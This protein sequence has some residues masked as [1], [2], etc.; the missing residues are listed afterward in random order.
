MT[1]KNKLHEK[2][3]G[4][5]MTAQRTTARTARRTARRVSCAAAVTAAAGLAAL[6]LGGA[7]ASTAA[8]AAVQTNCAARPSA[9][10]YP[11]ATN[12]GVPAGT[13]LKTVPGQ[14]TS[15]TG[16]SYSTATGTLTVS[17][18]GATLTG[19]KIT[20]NVNITASNV[21]L[22]NDTVVS[23]GGT[24][25][26]S[27]RHTANVTIQNSNVGGANATTGRVNYAVDDIY[28]DS[29]GLVV[30]NDNITNWRVGVNA[31]AGL[32][33]ANYIHSPGF[34]AG[35]HTDGIYDSEG[36]SQL[37]ISNNT[38]LNS[39]NQACAIMLQSAAGVP[40]SNL[41]VTGNFLAGGGYTIYAGGAQNDSTN[42]VITG[43]RFGQQYFTTS[44]Q[45]G[46]DAQYQASGAGNTWSGN[47][48]DTTG[49]TVA[50]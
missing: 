21:T 29:T 42:I 24:F 49:T 33:T 7:F 27:L 20:G 15:G 17:G 32:I 28:G 40:V 5:V 34:Q 18:N 39:L 1:A 3:T 35:D 26:I 44:G 36:T 16:W 19:L 31:E 25:G 13:T 4:D 38:I 23:D 8:S 12:T 9:C 47:I 41:A 37:T 46:P 11:D 6:T 43:N 22:N 14:V 45:Y 50:H 30:K 2:Q 10:G 48:W